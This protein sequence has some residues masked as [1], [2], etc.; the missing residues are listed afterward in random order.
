VTAPIGSVSL[1]PEAVAGLEPFVV[2]GVLLPVD[3]HLAA[4]VVRLG[5][6]AHIELAL[7]AALASRAPR[8][9]H[10]CIDL[11]AVAGTT[12]ADHPLPWPAPDAWREALI[13][14]PVVVHVDAD[15]PPTLGDPRPLV[16][17]GDR[18]YLSR[19]W[20]DEQYVAARLR[21]LATLP[22]DD[23][24][25]GAD[26]LLDR[27]FPADP[28]GAVDLQRL[29]AETIL[30]R[31]LT[32]VVGGP[33]TGK[34]RTLARVLALVQHRSAGPVRVALAA[35]TGKAAA[36][37]GEAVAGQ[38][39]DTLDDAAAADALAASATPTTLHRLLGLGSRRRRP[40]LDHDLIIVDE[41]S[42]VSLGLV[43]E[44]LRALPAHTRLVLVGDPDQLTSVE[45]GTVLADLVQSS[46]AVGSPLHAAV[47]A[48]QRPYRFG[49]GSAIA[50]VADAVRSGD[51]AAL[52]SWCAQ[53]DGAVRFHEAD[54]PLGVAGGAGIAE[55]VLPAATRAWEAAG[56]GDGSGALAA[57][58]EVRLLCAHRSGR[59]G[60]AAWNRRIETWLLDAVP[61]FDPT[62]TWHVGRPILITRNDAV[63]GLANGDVGIVIARP[64]GLAGAD[65][66][67]GPG[68]ARAGD[69][70]AGDHGRAAVGVAV[71]R[72]GRIVLLRPV[73][74]P[75]H[76]TFH[77]MTIHKSQ[78]SEFDAVVV[79]LPPADSPLATRELLYTA[80][81]RARSSLV[82]VGTSDALAAAV[83]RRVHRA[84]G[85][86]EALDQASPG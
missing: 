33:G 51:L 62:S 21:D 27:W 85:L 41:A 53:V 31:R 59:H 71:E 78:G 18:L 7:A 37:M 77:A 25:A 23:W 34:T 38:L 28:S 44:L 22:A 74:V 10:V 67:V 15:G 61:G 3:V 48:L 35:P 49:A 57:L 26:D 81:T 5:G 52:E 40:E 54:D 73:Q 12:A 2:A 14:S 43:A 84:S 82:I 80:I 19:W 6:D 46:R 56:R 8:H 20:F 13:A 16:L 17:A 32:V 83:G 76:E 55:R 72:G 58:R 9:G 65:G 4:A 42:M 64:E 45:A 70:R 79:L 30:T 1:V 86:V 68:G 36:R 66:G 60:I 75:E 39:H 63:T 24:R 50:G 47:V 29:A 69:A 11:G